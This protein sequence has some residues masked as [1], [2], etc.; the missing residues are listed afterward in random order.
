MTRLLDEVIADLRALA[1]EEQDR[2]ANALL[3]FM[4]FL[5]HDLDDWQMV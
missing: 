4:H 3:A 2:A 1:P 5:Q